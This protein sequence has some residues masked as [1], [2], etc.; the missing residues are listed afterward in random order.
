MIYN[1]APFGAS[2]IRWEKWSC[3]TFYTGGYY[4]KDSYYLDLTKSTAFIPKDRTHSV[5][6][7]YEWGGRDEGWIGTGQHA[8]T[9]DEAPNSN[10]YVVTGIYVFPAEE[11]A[12]FGT[13]AWGVKGRCVASAEYVDEDEFY[14]KGSTDY[15][16]V[17]AKRG[18]LPE[19]GTLIEG[20]AT[21]EYCIIDVNGTKYY[22]TRL[23]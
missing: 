11:L 15:G 16:T 2:G 6:A 12:I 18:E 20:S 13:G 22:Y 9:F 10:Y 14:T 21:G 4:R 23:N 5:F 19:S 17:V 8:L 3:N 7:D 1:V